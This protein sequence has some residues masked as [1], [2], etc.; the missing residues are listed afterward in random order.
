MI[1]IDGYLVEHFV[2]GFICFVLTVCPQVFKFSVSLNGHIYS[3]FVCSFFLSE[4][5]KAE[6][7][8]R[9]VLEILQS[10]D[11]TIQKLQQVQY[12]FI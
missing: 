12:S 11:D 5:H 2:S 3:L 10:K 8:D 9:K 7:K 6:M 4:K 1:L